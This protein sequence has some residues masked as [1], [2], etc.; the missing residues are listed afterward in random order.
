[1]SNELKGAIN[2]GMSFMVRMSIITFIALAVFTSADTTAGTNWD[3]VKDD[4]ALAAYATDFPVEVLTSVAYIESSFRKEVKADGSSASG[5]NQITKATWAYLIEKYG[6]DYQL[7][8]DTSPFDPRANSIMAAMYLTE[9]GD[10]MSHR[11]KREVTPLEMYLG[12][13]FSPY[14][15]VKMLRVKSSTPLIDFYPSASNRNLA[16]YYKEDGSARTIKDVMNMF[17]TRM[18]Y[19]TKT[20]G[21]E[22]L[23]SVKDLKEFEFLPFRYALEQAAI[24]CIY[25]EPEKEPYSIANTHIVKE[26][27]DVPGELLASY[28]NYPSSGRTFNGFFI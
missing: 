17:K 23:A 12:Y 2:F 5:L 24:D 3:D 26:S 14:R 7:P 21:E 20:Y 1:M 11:L 13:K 19:A 4:I 22:A 6:P 25:E 18:E 28:K 27:L 15:A 10:I 16:V 9:I 8:S